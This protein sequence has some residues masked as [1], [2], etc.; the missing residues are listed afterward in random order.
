[1]LFR[2]ALEIP[3]RCVSGHLYDPEVRETSVAHVWAEAHL[4]AQLGWVGFDPAS[5]LCPTDRWIRLACGLDA[6]DVAPIRG[7]RTFVGTEAV[8]T[9]ITVKDVG[10]A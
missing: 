7:W 3:V 5:N 9:R 10:P 4:G 2:S 8:T 6:L 1:M